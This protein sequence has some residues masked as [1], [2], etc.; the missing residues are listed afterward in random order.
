M[1]QIRKEEGCVK[2]CLVFR[3]IKRFTPPKA[4]KRKGAK[5]AENGILSADERG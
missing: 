5:G 2:R 4:G 1:R 3:G